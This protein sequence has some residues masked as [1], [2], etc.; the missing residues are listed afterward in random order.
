[1]KRASIHTIVIVFAMLFWTPWVSAHHPIYDTPVPNILVVLDNSANWGPT[2]KLDGQKRALIDILLS[3][4][5]GSVNIG[6]MMHAETGGGDSS[7]DGG[8]LR[9]ALR[10]IDETTRAAYIQ[11]LGDPDN[12]SNTGL[13]L[14]HD[15]SNGAKLGLTMAEAY[16]YFSGSTPHAGSSKLKTDFAGNTF[17]NHSNP[18]SASC[19][20]D[21]H[22]V[23]ALPGN[24]LDSMHSTQYGGPPQQQ[25]CEDANFIIYISNGPAGDNSSDN[26]QANQL[27]TAAGGDTTPIPL[28]PGGYSDLVAD[29]WARFMRDSSHR[30]RTTVINAQRVSNSSQCESSSNLSWRALLNSMAENGGGDFHQLC[31]TSLDDTQIFGAIEDFTNSLVVRICT[32]DYDS[33]EVQDHQDNC[34]HIPNPHQANFDGEDDGGNACDSDDDNDGWEDSADNCPLNFNPDQTDTDGD[35]VGD[36]CPLPPGC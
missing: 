33:D 2:E 26:V 29:E 32:Q 1:M 3:L 7:V 36:A 17:L 35:G 11:L 34:P 24:A 10:P 23:W 20:T 31:G 13:D 5:D 18:D 4:P 12:P 28:T 6:L 8:Y 15:R 22:P 21:S 27:L 25:T 30:I 14:A 9:A 16:L 19:C